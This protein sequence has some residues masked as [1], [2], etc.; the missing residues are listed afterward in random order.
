MAGRIRS[1]KPEVLEDEVASALSD[2]AWRLWVSMWTLADDFGN[3]RVGERYLASTV[4][5]DSTRDVATPLGEL[6][7]R[8]FISPYAVNAQR[9]GHIN[10]WEKHQRVDNA[11][12]A[13]VPSPDDDDGTWNQRLSG[14]FAASLR[15]P[16]RLAETLRES[17]TTPE[18]S[19][20]A[21]RARA[22]S[23]GRTTTTTTT[24]TTTRS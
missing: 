5:Q 3:L 18:D 4:W 1:I 17:E 22:H 23:G 21:R 16:P 20:L 12:K 15:E 10:G 14:R 19:P 7:S 11:G 9:Y 2:A 6:L 13:R 24:T 8:G